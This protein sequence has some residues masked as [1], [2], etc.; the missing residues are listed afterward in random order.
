ME[1]ANGD[2][3]NMLYA[4]LRDVKK[5]CSQWV[6]ELPHV[7]YSKNTAFHSGINC[8]PFSVYFRRKPADSGL[9]E[10]SVKSKGNKVTRLHS[11]TSSS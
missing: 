8:T 9:G 1:R 2:F 3:K 5:E 4:G 6:S 10:G 11:S 7:Q